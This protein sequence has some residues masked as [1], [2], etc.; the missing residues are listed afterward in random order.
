MHE[1]VPHRPEQK[2]RF[3][4]EKQ[5]CSQKTCAHHHILEVLALIYGRV[6]ACYGEFVCAGTV[7]ERG[8]LNISLARHSKVAVTFIDFPEGSNFYHVK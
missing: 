6:L 2:A 8:K 7:A 5:N 1:P 3:A 4:K